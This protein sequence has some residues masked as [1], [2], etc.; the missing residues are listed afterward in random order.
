MRN[1]DYEADELADLAMHFYNQV[2]V[3]SP[4]T[5]W[6]LFHML[7]ERNKPALLELLERNGVDTTK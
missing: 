4:G 5:V 7:A 2:A 6:T 1:Q 3:P